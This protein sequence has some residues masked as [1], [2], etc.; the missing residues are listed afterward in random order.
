VPL[1]QGIIRARPEDFVVDERLDFELSGAGEHV[2]L[3]LRKRATNTEYLARALA[4]IAGV[5]VREVGYAGLKDRHAVTSQWFSVRLPGRAVE[6]WQGRLPDGVEVLEATRHARKLQKGALAGNHFTVTVR[7]CAG[8]RT[9]FARRLEAIAAH[10]VPNYF[11]EQRFGRDATNVAHAR[12]M[13]TGDEPVRETAG[14]PSLARGPRLNPIGDRHRRGIYLSAARAFLFNE[15][16]ARRVTDGTWW[17]LLDGEAVMLAGSRSFFV[18]EKIDDVLRERLARHD[19]HPSGPLWG[20]GELPTGGTVRVLEE[21]V[22]APYPEL[23]RGLAAEGLRQERR[24]LRL[25]PQA[26]SAHWSDEKTLV[27]S[28][29]LP[30]GSY[31]TTLLR[32][33]VDYRDAAHEAPQG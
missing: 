18:V 4:R 19:V 14:A 5:P 1:T 12:A 26:L 25:L 28:F 21:Q 6:V 32:E 33:L 24:A 3:R 10:G 23:T 30:A 8:D 27:L 22:V 7:D 29:A 31:A 9:L 15:V 17:Q 13:L 16:L 2:W 11:G 20:H